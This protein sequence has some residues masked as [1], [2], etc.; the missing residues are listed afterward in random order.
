MINS[1]NIKTGRL[2][3]LVKLSMFLFLGGC[4]VLP[5]EPIRVSPIRNELLL[6]DVCRE[7][8]IYWQWDS[9][10][11]VVTLHLPDGEAK[12]LVGSNM[13]LVGDRKIYLDKPI[14]ISKSTIIVSLDFERKV[15]GSLSS[16]SKDV[17]QY[18]L[19]KIRSVVID[20]GHGG[21]DPGAIGRTGLYE[22]KVVLDISRRVQKI[23]ERHKIKVVMTRDSD[24]FVTLKKRTELACAANV[25]I[26]VSIHANASLTRSASGVE[27]YSLRELD[28]VG[29]NEEQ[30]KLNA[31]IM[32]KR[33]S[34]D[35]N[36]SDLKA[37]VSDMLYVKKK[38]E[39]DIL[40]QKVV[41]RIAK[42]TKA[43]NRGRKESQF[44][45]VRNTL[46]P[47]ILVEVGFL[48]N[49]R[50]ERLFKKS[51]YR[52]RVAVGLARGI[53]DYARSK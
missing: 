47:A 28:R 37:I 34:M 23:L 25:D 50:E 43:R 17:G 32:N 53:L 10:S 1:F 19:R 42:F 44:F 49:S 8:N 3:L 24:R 26:F 40:A 15:F 35:K 16:R 45:V 39:S 33:L 30:R 51:A 21:K 38:P 29:R 20:A 14:K 7:N 5:T 36:S 41:K 13:V 46:M 31:R 2:Y 6:K 12:I 27:V 9:I 52:Q 4:A 11:Q 22:K 18:V 48:S